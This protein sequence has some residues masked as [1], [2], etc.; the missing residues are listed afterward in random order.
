MHPFIL[1]ETALKMS[2]N[3]ARIIAIMAHIEANKPRAFPRF[4]YWKAENVCIVNLQRM[5][6]L[7]VSAQRLKSFDEAY[8]QFD[9]NTRSVAFFAFNFEDYQTGDT[10]DDETGPLLWDDIEASL[11][12]FLT[13]NITDLSSSASPMTDIARAGGGSPI[14]S[15]TS[16]TDSVVTGTDSS[17]YRRTGPGAHH[18]THR[19]SQAD[20]FGHNT[21]YQYP[22]N[23]YGGET[24]KTRAAF[25]DRLE[26]C[27][28]ANHTAEALEWIESQLAVMTAEKK[29]DAMEAILRFLLVDRLNIPTMLGLLRGTTAMTESKERK[30]FQEK[31]LRHIGRIQ[32]KAARHIVATVM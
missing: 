26:E 1:R 18:H 22:Q 21:N 13:M 23:T 3:Y 14:D 24:Y 17:Y 5:T 12:S 15:P 25:T 11:L 19:H 29:I 10:R 30:D 31:C 27:L 2:G 28:K 9:A 4:F 16:H 6:S 20:N 32:T 7:P 8:L